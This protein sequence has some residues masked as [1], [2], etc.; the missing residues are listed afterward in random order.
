MPSAPSGGL[1]CARPK[2]LPSSAPAAPIP[3]VNKPQVLQASLKC[4]GLS[5]LVFTV[6]IIHEANIRRDNILF[7]TIHSIPNGDKLGH[8]LLAGTL[9]LTANFLLR[10]SVLRRGL[11]MVPYGSLI[12]LGV[13][14]AEEASQHFIPTRTLDPLDALANLTGIILCSI[15]AVLYAKRKRAY[16]TTEKIAA[17]NKS[18]PN[19]RRNNTPRC[20]DCSSF[21]NQ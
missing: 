17:T 13:A 19:K 15:P 3:G 5:F 4:F 11:I 6:W 16:P 10:C 12:V 20:S 8:V 14:M 18:D 1:F 2:H 21:E 9:T 7:Q